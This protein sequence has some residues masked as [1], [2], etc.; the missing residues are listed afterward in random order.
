M[1]PP[2][3]PFALKFDSIEIDP[4]RAPSLAAIDHA[5]ALAAPTAAAPEQAPRPGF[6][7]LNDAGGRFVVDRDIG[8]ISVKDDALIAAEHGSVHCVRMRV[9]EPSG[10]IYELDMRLRVT[11]RVPQMVGGEEFASL[12]DLAAAPAPSLTPIT[13]IAMAP[14]P[15]PHVPWAHFSALDDIGAPA[16]LSTCGGLPYGAMFGATLPAADISPAALVLAETPPP[17]A[18]RSAAWPI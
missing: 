9:V 16:P 11:G 12:V 15:R 8:I 3:D 5:F 10:A 13:R 1:I 4:A 18:P 7:L 6:Y 14:P 17:P 2:L